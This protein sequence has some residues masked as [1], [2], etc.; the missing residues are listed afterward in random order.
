MIIDILK[1]LE[2]SKHLPWG[3]KL[4]LG[5]PANAQMANI[6]LLMIIGIL[7]KL[8]LDLYQTILWFVLINYLIERCLYDI[9]FR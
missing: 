5:Q 8:K 6:F 1:G 3:K 9:Y 4:A 7:F 2:Y